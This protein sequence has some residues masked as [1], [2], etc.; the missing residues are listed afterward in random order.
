MFP[1]KVDENIFLI[2]PHLVELEKI[3]SQIVKK[4]TNDIL[5]LI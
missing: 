1:K 3:D 4:S 2:S 5:I